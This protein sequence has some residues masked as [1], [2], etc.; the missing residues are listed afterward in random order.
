MTD[1]I[2]HAL[3]HLDTEYIE[4]DE[5][6]ASVIDMQEAG[7]NYVYVTVVYTDNGDTEKIVVVQVTYPDEFDR[8]TLGP[9]I[10]TTLMEM[11]H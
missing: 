10:T 4:E 6:K 7:F 11:E 2:A 3:R 1:H 8:P 5:Y 9:V